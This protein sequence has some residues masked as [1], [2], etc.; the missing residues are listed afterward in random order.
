MSADIQDTVVSSVK[1]SKVFT[2]LVDESTDI[3]GKA[4]LLAFI[5]FVNDG[6][7]DDQFFCCKEFK[8]T[9]TGQGILIL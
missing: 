3:S 9:T 5:R 7:I 8:E 1:Q 6:K 2:M 4:K